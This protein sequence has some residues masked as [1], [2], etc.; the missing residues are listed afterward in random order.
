MT[1]YNFCEREFI[2]PVSF[3]RY[4]ILTVKNPIGFIQHESLLGAIWKEYLGFTYMQ[5]LANEESK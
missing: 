3:M 1:F 2:E 5:M 4:I